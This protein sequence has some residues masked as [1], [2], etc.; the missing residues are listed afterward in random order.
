MNIQNLEWSLIQSFLAVIRS[1]SL[2]AAGR[3][4]M[5]S[6]PTV[7]RHITTLEEQLGAKLFQRLPRALVPTE[8]A[9]KLHPVAQDMAQA[10]AQ[11]QLTAAGQ[12]QDISGPVRITASEV[13]STYVLPPILRD[14]LNAHARIEIELVVSNSNE[15][16]LM[17]EADIAVRMVRPTQNDLVMQKLAELPL[18]LFASRDYLDAHGTP[19]RYEDLADHLFIGY[20]RNDQIIREMAAM[21]VDVS[22]RDFRFRCDDQALHVQALLAGMGIGATQVGV[23]SVLGLVQVLPDIP[24]RPLPMY[25]VAHNELSGSARV[26]RVFDMLAGA[27]R[28]HAK[29][30]GSDYPSA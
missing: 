11:L 10:A 25:L 21:G 26:R 24:I 17:R 5:L 22:P 28:A 20:D 16:L 3:E 15:N 27:L 6:Q 18:G 12:A 14:I 8:L 4:L 9:T 13:V 23:A 30:A 19:R 29:G 2:S 7:G 1:G